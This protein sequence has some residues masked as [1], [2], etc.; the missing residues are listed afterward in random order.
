M[1]TPTRFLLPDRPHWRLLLRLLRCPMPWRPRPAHPSGAAPEAF[2]DQ[3]PG[4]AL[5]AMT[6]TIAAAAC[7]GLGLRLVPVALP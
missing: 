3:L 7:Q 6:V 4:S 5:L 1:P 2:H